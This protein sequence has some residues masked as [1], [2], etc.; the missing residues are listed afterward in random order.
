MLAGNALGW[1]AQGG[2]GVRH[3]GGAR[4]GDTHAHC[5]PAARGGAVQPRRAPLSVRCIRLLRQ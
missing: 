2:P 5:L 3:A 1:G 4:A